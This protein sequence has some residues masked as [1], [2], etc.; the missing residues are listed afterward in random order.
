MILEFCLGVAREADWLLAG[1]PRVLLRDPT[2]HVRERPLLGAWPH[3]HLAARHFR[4]LFPH[5][6]REHPGLI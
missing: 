4:T 3:G 1:E 2:E 5:G 6:Q